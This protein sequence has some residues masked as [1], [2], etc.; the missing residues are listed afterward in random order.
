[1]HVHAGLLQLRRA[2]GADEEVALDLGAA[3]RAL[4]LAPAEPRLHLL[5]L[6]LPLA[7]VVE[8]L[9]RA[10]QHVDEQADERHEA[11]QGAIHDEPRILD[12]PARV[13]VHPVGEREPEDEQEEEQQALDD[14][15]RRGVEEVLDPTEEVARDEDGGFVTGV[16]C[17]SRSRPQMR[18]RAR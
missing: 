18:R 10:E 7:Y 14:A 3:H 15:P 6:E 5:D 12:P 1:M 8:V 9:R 17:L 11:E 2:D 4:E 13:L 16:V